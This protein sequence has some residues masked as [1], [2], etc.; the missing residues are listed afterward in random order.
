MRGDS[1][2]GC[3]SA[4]GGRLGDLWLLAKAQRW[5]STCGK[6]PAH[7]KSC[8]ALSQAQRWCPATL[9]PRCS[10]ALSKSQGDLCCPGILPFVFPRNAERREV[11]CGQSVL[12]VLLR[13]TPQRLRGFKAGSGWTSATPSCGVCAQHGA[14][15]A[16]SSGRGC[17][18]SRAPCVPSALPA[19]A[20]RP[21]GVVSTG[22]PAAG[23]LVR[24]LQ[25]IFFS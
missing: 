7:R 21:L 3:H 2:W 12:C 17:G 24:D 15:R 19:R 9:C 25:P 4:G 23:V 6:Q 14:R 8:G 1:C 22:L 16:G 13:D 10:R 5:G 20:V 18:A 11:L